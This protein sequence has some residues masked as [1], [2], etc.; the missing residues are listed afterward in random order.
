MTNLNIDYV[1]TE[2]RSKGKKKPQ[3]TR[4]NQETTVSY[5]LLKPYNLFAKRKNVL[6]LSQSTNT[7]RKDQ[8]EKSHGV[9]LVIKRQLLAGLGE[10]DYMEFI[11]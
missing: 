11:G 4:H 6:P 2:R 8:K 10:Q 5:Q 9:L 7:N 1:K 3:L